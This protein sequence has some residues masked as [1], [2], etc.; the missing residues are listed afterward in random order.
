MPLCDAPLRE[1]IKH[2]FPYLTISTLC[3]LNKGLSNKNYYLEQAQQ[4]YLL[5][6]YSST[7]P[8]QALQ[9][10]S[11]LAKLGVAQP[12]VGFDTKTRLA[13]FEFVTE[14]DEAIALGDQLLA[15]LHTLHGF[16]QPQIGQLDLSGALLEAGRVLDCAPQLTL[17][18]QQLAQFEADICFCHNDL[19]KDNMLVTLQ[20]PVF[21]DFEYAQYNDRYFDLAALCVSFS[22]SASEAEHMLKRYYRQAKLPCPA[23][24]LNKLSCYVQVYLWLCI[25][26]YQ[27]RKLHTYLG[28]LQAMLALWQS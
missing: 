4:G 20:G 10:Q 3:P 16:D 17:L 9:A 1:L 7:L 14:S 2:A 22:L 19:V 8:V 12:V 26:W 23:F 6:H 27:Q 24:A 15:Q 18:A 21:I 5:K 25:A 11:Q 13:L 28:P